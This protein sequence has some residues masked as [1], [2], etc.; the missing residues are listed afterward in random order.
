MPLPVAGPHD[1]VGLGL[2]AY[3]VDSGPSICSRRDAGAVGA[4][5]RIVSLD[6]VPIA[7]GPV[8]GGEPKQ[9]SKETWR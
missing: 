3:P 4:F 1:L 6:D 5:A 7:G 8:V 9:R 2:A